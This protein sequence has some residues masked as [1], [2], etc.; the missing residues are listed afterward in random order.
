MVFGG[1]HGVEAQVFGFPGIGRQILIDVLIV[2]LRI[3]A[4]VCGWPSHARVGHVDGAEEEGSEP[5]VDLL[6]VSLLMRCGRATCWH[7][8]PP[9]R[10]S[11]TQAATIAYCRPGRDASAE[12]TKHA[13]D[14][15]L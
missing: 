12:L 10:Y 15:Q 9:G 5:Q 6:G 11:D 1:P 7:V 13:W 4:P 2:G 14:C 8:A 3:A